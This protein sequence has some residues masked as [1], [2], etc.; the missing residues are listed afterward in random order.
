MSH[1]SGQEARIRTLAPISRLSLTDQ[2][3]V[4]S[5]GMFLTFSAGEIVYAQGRED[6]YANYLLEGSVEFLWNGRFVRHLDAE[7]SAI[8]RALDGPGAKRYTVRAR[9]WSLVLRIERTDLERK[10][11]LAD[12]DP[13]TSD[14]EDTD[15]AREQPSNWMIRMLQSQRFANLPPQNIQRVFERMERVDAT[16]NELIIRQGD[17][18]GYYYVIEEGY[19]DVSREP[20]GGG[21]EVHLAELGPGD[22]FGE[23]ALVS[24]TPRNASVTMRSDGVLM[25]LDKESFVELIRNPLINKV[26]YQ[27]AHRMIDEGAVWIDIRHRDQF[28]KGAFR[29][30]RNIPRGMIRVECRKLVKG[31]KYIVC[32]E[33]PGGSAAAAFLLAERG[34]DVSHLGEPLSK[35][36]ASE[37][38]PVQPAQAISERANSETVVPFPPTPD[39]IPDEDESEKSLIEKSMEDS[40]EPDEESPII[41]LENS[42]G[43]SVPAPRDAYADTVTGARLADLVEEINDHFQELEGTGGQKEGD[44]LDEEALDIAGLDEEAPAPPPEEPEEQEQKEAP[45]EPVQPVAELAQEIPD[46]RDFELSIPEEEMSQITREMLLK[47]RRCVSAFASAQRLRYEEQ[48]RTRTAQVEVAATKELHRKAEEIRLIYQSKFEAKELSLRRHYQRLVRLANKITRQK[49][50]LQQARKELEGKLG[51][52]DSLYR[53][54]HDIRQMLA[55]RIGNLDGLEEEDDNKSAS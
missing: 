28:A 31:R 15:I 41:D 52:T 36:F 16:A 7:Q 21:R 4:L 53:E 10:L 24:D 5:Q 35:L 23:E 49:A 11:R 9:T 27:E 34:Y 25:R 43:P 22:G 50:E 30:A 12:L 39:E 32:G 51:A 1:T 44:T 18:G 45:V 17:P 48:L 6:N 3:A 8:K 42:F 38:A 13:G 20:T 37:E 47:L 40:N 55:K 26:S 29:N 14:L 19:C 46:I 33:D 54:V 2:E